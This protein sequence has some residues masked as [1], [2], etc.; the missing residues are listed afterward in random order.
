MRYAPPR[1][2]FRLYEVMKI[3]RR[4][5]RFLEIG[6]GNL[7]LA[8][9]LLAKFDTG[10]LIDFNTTNVEQIFNS[11]SNDKKRKMK[12]VIA[13][14]SEYDGSEEMFNCVVFCEV[15]EHV[16]EDGEFLKK[17]HNLLAK[18]G[19]I[20]LSVP[21]RQKYW[22][23]HDE[24][25]GHK[26]RYEKV[27]LA[28]KLTNAGFSQVKII[29]YGFPFINITRLARIALASL[30]YRE[31][32]KWDSKTQTQQSSFNIKPSPLL[33]LISILINKYTFLPLSLL[34]SLFNDLDLSDGYVATAIKSTN[35]QETS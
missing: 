34:A 10:T 12:L 8:L 18:D 30:Q 9:E 1:F 26:R 15:L 35:A 2:L 31:K 7:M 24:I 13:D 3:T 29:S 32:S 23:I 28:Q 20:V 25:V 19:Q 21:S 4:G 16:E 27:E 17:V 11:L 6:P 33:D 5:N 14:F 22:S